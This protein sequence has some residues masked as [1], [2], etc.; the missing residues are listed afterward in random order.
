MLNTKVDKKGA[1]GGQTTTLSVQP[2]GSESIKG[3]FQEN[4]RMKYTFEK[5]NYEFFEFSNIT[6]IG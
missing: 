1:L 4:Y 5:L 2:S 6:I 3:S